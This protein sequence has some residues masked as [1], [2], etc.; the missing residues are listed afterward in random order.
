[1]KSARGPR[2]DPIR[3]PIVDFRACRSLRQSIPCPEHEEAK[4]SGVEIALRGKGNFI[5]ESP[6]LSAADCGCGDELHLRL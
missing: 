1:V 6:L 5:V 4:S 2:S 3:L